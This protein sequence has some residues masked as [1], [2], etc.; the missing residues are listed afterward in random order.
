MS[1]G[2]DLDAAR[3][4]FGVGKGRK[5]HPRSLFPVVPPKEKSS[6]DSGVYS[7]EDGEDGETPKASDSKKKKP[8]GD[9]SD[10]EGFVHQDADYEGPWVVPTAPVIGPLLPLPQSYAGASD[11]TP[12]TPPAATSSSLCPGGLRI[13]TVREEDTLQEFFP[14]SEVPKLINLEARKD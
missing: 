8:D 7:D 1:K 2:G 12:P 10:E 4:A 13:V 9:E 6:G 11:L 14:I 5:S 3:T